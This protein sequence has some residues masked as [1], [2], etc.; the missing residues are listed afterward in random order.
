MTGLA[1]SGPPDGLTSALAPSP[2]ACA[3]DGFLGR[4]AGRDLGHVDGT[5]GDTRRLGRGGGGDRR[6]S[7]PAC[8]VGGVRSDARYRGSRPGCSASSRA[9][10]P[11]ARTIA[12]APSEIGGRSWRRSGSRTYGSL[13]SV[14]TSTSPFSLSVGVVMAA[15]R[16]RAATSA[17]SRS[18]T[19]PL[20]SRARACRPAR[21]T[22]S[23]PIGCEVVGIEL[24][25][26]QGARVGR[27]RLAR[28]E[29][30]G[31]VDVAV[32]QAY[33]RFVQRPG[34]VHL[35][36]GLSDR[37]PGPGGFQVGHEGERAARQVVA[38]SAAR[39]ADVAASDPGH[40]QRRRRWR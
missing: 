24:L 35:D 31:G 4:E 8:R 2:S 11:A 5:A 32:L 37:R 38:A 27:R 18:V 12:E 25:G 21:D 23:I 28:A 10:S 6:R 30:Q 16:L 26:V 34:S 9:R 13:S 39:E 40:L 19:W 29:D 22:G 14:S 7:G 3:E 20:S 36:V 1:A 33:P 17:K 15:R